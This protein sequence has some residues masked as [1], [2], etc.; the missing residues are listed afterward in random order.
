[1]WLWCN[2]QVG[3][4]AKAADEGERGLQE[5]MMILMPFCGSSERDDDYSDGDDD[6]NESI[7]DRC[8]AHN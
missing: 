8:R 3:L 1:M 5:K 2:A 6:E 7:N 4:C